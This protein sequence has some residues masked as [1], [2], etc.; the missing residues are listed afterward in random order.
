MSDDYGYIVSSP[1]TRAF[2][3]Q[4]V[5]EILD[6]FGQATRY[7]VNYGSEVGVYSAGRKSIIIA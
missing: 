4:S 3:V 7:T 6:P 5:L 1:Y 2:D